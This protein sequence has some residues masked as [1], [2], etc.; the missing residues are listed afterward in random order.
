MWMEVQTCCHGHWVEI[1]RTNGIRDS[2]LYR[3]CPLLTQSVFYPWVYLL[4]YIKIWLR[5]YPSRN[6]M[7]K[8]VFFFL[9]LLTTIFSLSTGC[10]RG[11]PRWK[12]SRRHCSRWY[13]FH[14]YRMWRLELTRVSWGKLYLRIILFLCCNLFSFSTIIRKF[15]TVISFIFFR[16][17]LTQPQPTPWMLP[18]L[19]QS[20]LQRRLLHLVR[21]NLKKIERCFLFML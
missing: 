13:H 14:K 8:Q 17:Q 15:T 20:L 6:E 18:K 10:D 1:N 4:K 11:N 19:L 21:I 5:S 2:F 7:H 16:W 12:L 9:S 3:K